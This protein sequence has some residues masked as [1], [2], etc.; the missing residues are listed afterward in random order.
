MTLLRMQRSLHS[1]QYTG[2][3]RYGIYLRMF[4]PTSHSFA[5]LTRSISIWTLEDKFHIAKHVFFCSLYKHMYILSWTIP[6]NMPFYEMAIS[7]TC[8]NCRYFS[9]VPVRDVS[10]AENLIKHCGLYNKMFYHLLLLVFCRESLGQE[11]HQP[12][13]NTVWT[14]KPKMH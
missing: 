10:V 6:W 3:W 12:R 7:D 4:K 1:E 11:W 2:P 9:H 5:A 14:S 8:E 13:Q